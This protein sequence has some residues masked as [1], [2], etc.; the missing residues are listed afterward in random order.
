MVGIGEGS[1]R[2]SVTS[3]GERTLS[4]G[5]PKGGP[6][7]SHPGLGSAQAYT[8]TLPHTA[9]WVRYDR[10]HSL[11]HPYATTQPTHPWWVYG[12]VGSVGT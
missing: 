2:A 9:P 6:V 5:S 4:P 8:F 10:Y 7:Y 11:P 12:W 1:E 3:G